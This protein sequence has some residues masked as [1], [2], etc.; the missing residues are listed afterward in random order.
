[1]ITSMVFTFVGVDKPGLIE[2]V[3]NTV[4]QHGGNWLESRMSQLAG[5]FAGIAR[6]HI[7]SERREA[8]SRALQ[9]L[10]DTGLQVVVAPQVDGAN[11]QQRQLQLSLLGNDR[12]GILN[13]LSRALATQHINVCEMNTRLTSAPMTA[14]L[15]F[16]ATATIEVPDGVDLAQL[17]DQLEHIANQLTVD[18]SLE[19]AD[20]T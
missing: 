17:N 1:M 16:E 13:E 20:A 3:S 15:L 2:E 4:S 8:L 14:D 11:S 7:D 5:Q 18:I 9:A 10:T 19:E 6:I 12:P